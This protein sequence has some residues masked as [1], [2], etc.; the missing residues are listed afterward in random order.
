ML[1]PTTPNDLGSPTPVTPNTAVQAEHRGRRWVTS[2]SRPNGVA[3][4]AHERATP[5]RVP[6]QSWERRPEGGPP[7]LF[8]DYAK[9]PTSSVPILSVTCTTTAPF[10]IYG[11]LGLLLVSSPLLHSR[12]STRHT[13][14]LLTHQPGVKGVTGY[15]SSA[16]P[17]C[18]SMSATSSSPFL[19]ASSYVLVPAGRPRPRSGNP[20][21]SG[22][23]RV[24]VHLHV[25]TAD[26]DCTST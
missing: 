19:H 23:E 12:S 4:A 5:L 16:A 20:E 24:P 22:V 1:M 3:L 8:D 25:Q 15:C 11:L 26:T 13:Y 9:L 6:P 10:F 2:A 7:R 21:P 18:M 14:M 17:R